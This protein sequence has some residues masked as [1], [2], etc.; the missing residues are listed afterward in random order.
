[1]PTYRVTSPTGKSLKITGNTPPTEQDLDGIFNESS[2]RSGQSTVGTQIP[3][4]VKTDNY[5]G[6]VAS[7]ILPSGVSMVKDIGSALINTVNPDMEKNTLANLGKLGIGTA[8]YLDP[9]QKLGTQY[10][11]KARAVGNFYKDRYGGLE[12][13]KETFRSDPVGVA[14]DVATVVSLGAGGVKTASKVASIAGKAGTAEKLASVGNTLTKVSNAVD[15]LMASTKAVG[16]VGTFAKT[17]TPFLKKIPSVSSILEKAS[18]DVV[19]AGLGKTN[20]LSD[21]T[22]KIKALDVPVYE[23]FDRNNLWERTPDVAQDAINVIGE[24]RGSLIRSGENVKLIDVFNAYDDL[25]KKYEP[26]VLRGSETAIEAIK[27]IDIR[28]QKFIDSLEKTGALK[29]Q[30]YRVPATEINEQMKVI[31]EDIPEAKYRW[32]TPLTPK[33]KADLS[34]QGTLRKQL[35][36]AS[37]GTKKL[38]IEESALIDLSNVFKG[39]GDRQA[40]KQVLNFSKLGTGGIGAFLGGL[41]G[42]IGGFLLESIANSP[43]GVKF[44]SKSLYSLSKADMS[45]LKEMIKNAYAGSRN[46]SKVTTPTQNSVFR[47]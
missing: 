46:I 3:G 35:E 19:L 33:Q 28:K 5:W 8:Q 42:F 44:L 25:K 30:P 40:A 1:M 45:F 22:A 15:P 13:I 16:K 14:G 11:D 7:N 18:N 34:I 41:P 39:Y 12:N 26:S 23:I 20:K 31:G 38:G 32:N 2:K 24:T 9:T 4:S 27:Q 47:R 17:N 36:T 37:P 10:E 43:Q 29:N 21:A 6:D